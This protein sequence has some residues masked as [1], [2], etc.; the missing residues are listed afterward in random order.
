MQQAVAFGNSLH[1]SSDNAQELE[2]AIAPFRQAP[3]DWRRI[4]SGL[5]DAFINLMQESTDN[6]SP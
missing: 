3:Y 4:P 1:V 2:S 5:E 6:F